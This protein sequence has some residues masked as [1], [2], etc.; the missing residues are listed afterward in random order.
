MLTAERLRAAGY[1]PSDI[2]DETF[3]RF[4]TV[5]DPDGYRIQVNEMDADHQNLSYEIRESAALK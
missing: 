2:T 1:A 5:N 4:F 3:G